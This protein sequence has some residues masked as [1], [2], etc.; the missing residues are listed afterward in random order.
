MRLFVAFFQLTKFYDPCRGGSN[1]ALFLFLLWSWSRKYPFFWPGI[2]FVWHD[3]MSQ[4]PRTK[5]AESDWAGTRL[6]VNRTSLSPDVVWWMAWGCSDI[7]ITSHGQ[8]RIIL[9]RGCVTG[10]VSPVPPFLGVTV[11]QSSESPPGDFS[12]PRPRI[13]MTRRGNQ[14]MVTSQISGT[15]CLT[16]SDWYGPWSLDDQ[17]T[18]WCQ[19]RQ[20]GYAAMMC[21]HMR[22]TITHDLHLVMLITLQH[23]CST[24]HYI[25][26]VQVLLQAREEGKVLVSFTD[27]RRRRVHFWV[28]SNKQ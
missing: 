16:V 1:T 7:H 22:Y 13:T 19:G 6:R 24:L 21:W 9:V 14:R 26:V 27:S 28:A 18:Q 4:W 20:D 8:F 15:Q 5:S 10:P 25:T 12:R 17:M 11:T 3:C 23:T 2:L